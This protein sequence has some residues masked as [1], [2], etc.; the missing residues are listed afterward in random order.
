MIAKAKTPQAGTVSEDKLSDHEWRLKMAAEGKAVYVPGW[1]DEEVKAKR[2]AAGKADNR[3]S[4][5]VITLSAQDWSVIDTAL[6]D[7]F[8]VLQDIQRL[9]HSMAYQED[10]DQAWV[11]ATLRLAARAVASVEEREVAT[12]DRLD[13][14]IRQAIKGAQS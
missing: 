11:N 7:T 12:L 9:L 10:L 6:P 13:A 4:S 2:G 14:A 3:P 5:R 1:S 8:E